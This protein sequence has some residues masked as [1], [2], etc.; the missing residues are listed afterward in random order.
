MGRCGQSIITKRQIA[1]LGIAG[2][3]RKIFAAGYLGGKSFAA[4]VHPLAGVCHLPWLVD[5]ACHAAGF[6]GNIPASPGVHSQLCG[7][8]SFRVGSPPRR[9]VAPVSSLVFWAMLA[10]IS[11]IALIGLL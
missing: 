2:D 1:K 7:T 8:E 11:F 4:A 10:Y 6:F 9:T 5:F 3:Y